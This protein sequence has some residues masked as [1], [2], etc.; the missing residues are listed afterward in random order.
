MSSEG[1]PKRSRPLERAA[2]FCGKYGLEI[3]IMVAPMAGASPASL[4]IAV[5][6]A[7]GMGA[8]G[9]LMTPPAGIQ[10]WA[11]EFRS[12]SDGPFQ[13]N[14]WIPDPK[15][16]RDPA[17]EERIRKFL[18]AWGPPAPISA[19]DAV[20][21]DFDAQCEAFLEITPTAVSSIMGVFPS[22]FVSRLKQRRICVVRD[23]DNAGGGK[24]RARR[25]RG[26]HHRAGI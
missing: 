14:L 13:L 22:A 10:A 11:Q 8:M 15:P 18:E 26:R 1:G 21:P 12:G 3:P 17:A 2:T 9:A 24:D 23:R 4:S 25:R 5:A 20:P 6:N 19:A 7:G 16:G